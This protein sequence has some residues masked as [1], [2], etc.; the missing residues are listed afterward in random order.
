MIDSPPILPLADTS[1][2]SRFAD[3]ILLVVRSGRTERQ[4]LQRGLGAID[5]SRLLGLV[6]NDSVGHDE[7]DYYSRYGANAVE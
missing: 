6:V 5:R 2:W 7:K 1:V 4:A 3:G